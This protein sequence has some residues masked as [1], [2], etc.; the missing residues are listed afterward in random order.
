MPSKRDRIATV[1]RAWPS[2]W[3]FGGRIDEEPWRVGDRLPPSRVWCDGEPTDAVLAGTST[4]R[5]DDP[6]AAALLSQYFGDYLLLVS[7][8]AGLFGEDDGEM[9]IRDAVVEACVYVGAD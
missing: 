8:S 1:L 7:G 6:R 3:D 2:N 9:I 4:I 5:L